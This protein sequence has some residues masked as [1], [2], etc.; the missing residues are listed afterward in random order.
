MTFLLWSVTCTLWLPWLLRD[1]IRTSVSLSQASCR[2]SL[3]WESVDSAR[4]EVLL[5]RL[6]SPPFPALSPLTDILAVSCSKLVT[7]LALRSCPMSTVLLS[8]PLRPLVNCCCALNPPLDVPGPGVV[9]LTEVT[10]EEED[11]EPGP[12]V[13]ERRAWNISV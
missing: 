2:C 8:E 5:P 11:E 4:C 9:G 12:G 13:C 7:L 1:T 6:P 3:R 10:V